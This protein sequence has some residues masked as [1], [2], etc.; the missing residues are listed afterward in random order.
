VEYVLAQGGAAEGEALAKAVRAGGKFAD[1][2]RAFA[3]LG[4][5]P[6]GRGYS[7]VT[8]PIAPERAKM[9]RLSLV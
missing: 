4:H 2:K 3:E 9:R 8:P 6:D 7:E 5:A 1:Y